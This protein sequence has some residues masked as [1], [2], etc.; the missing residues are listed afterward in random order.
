[1]ATNSRPSVL[2]VKFDEIPA[3]FKQHPR[4]VLWR[5]TWKADR[6]QWAKVPYQVSGKLA[7]S[8]NSETWATYEAAVSAFNAGDYD[9]IGFMLGDGWD[10]LDLDDCIDPITGELNDMA[11]DAMATLDGY[12][13]FS[14][15]GTGL[16]MITRGDVRRSKKDNAKGIEYYT[17]GRYFTVTGHRINGHDAMPDL[18]QPISS[19]L[20]K[21]LEEKIEAGGD[22]DLDAL[23]YMKPSLSDWDAEKIQDELLDR[24]DADCGYDDWLQIG[25]ALHHQF[26]GDLEGLELWDTWSAESGKYVEGVCEQKWDSFS[27]QRFSGS[28]AVTLATVIKMA[29][30]KKT[31]EVVNVRSSFQA[32][33]Q[34]SETEQHL[35]ESVLPEI[36]QSKGL[37]KADRE[38][39]ATVLQAKW[40]AF[41]NSKLPID[42]AREMVAPPKTRRVSPDAPDWVNDWAYVTEGDKFF[43][44]ET[45][46]SVTAVGFNAKHNRLMGQYMMDE[47]RFPPPASKYATDFWHLPAV[48]TTAYLPFAEP[49]FSMNG[50]KMANTYR[51]CSIPDAVSEYTAEDLAAIK[52]V[53]DHAKRMIPDDVT[54]AYFL[55]YLAFNA[56]NPGRKIRWAP[57]I[58][59]CFGDGKSFWSNLMGL[60]LGGDNTKTV[61]VTTLSGSNFT[62]WA[63]GASFICFEEVKLHGHNSWDVANLIKPYLTNDTVE[64]HRKGKDPINLPNVSNYLAL[65]NYL[66][67]M[68]LEKGDRRWMV[69]ASAVSLEEAESEA[70]VSLCNKLFTTTEKHA[71]ALRKWLLEMPLCEGFNANG[72]A[73]MTEAKALSIEL[74]KSGLRV[75]AEDLL[76]RGGDGFCKEVVSSSH[77]IH[78]LGQAGETPKTTTVS[79]L[80]TEM[81]YTFI[82]RKRWRGDMRRVWVLRG[83]EVKTLSDAVKKLEEVGFEDDFLK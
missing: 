69:I 31:K 21:Y 44:L 48:T 73:P 17:S 57:Y 38:H 46:E 2:R 29:G 8:D 28:G 16:K 60:V 47:D 26:E 70:Y 12:A 43:N 63:T 80:L 42:I 51:T 7:A 50:L 61:N 81:S 78:A 33:I 13:E 22:T 23:M 72:R 59:G 18:A 24:L 34:E 9:G 62:S 6:K 15:S 25:M 40:V 11:N 83:S 79:K 54:R 39:L 53:E 4:W 5:Q 58:Y 10:G 66:D 45:K 76:E 74:S 35:R 3:E 56:R 64:I 20:T 19:F 14:P 36:R 55:S 32:K 77:L 52:L 68:P 82:G 30:V 67:G 37:D 49:V 75:A 27:E 41:N 65:S 1:M 71:G